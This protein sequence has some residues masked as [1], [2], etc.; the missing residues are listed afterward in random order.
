MAGES[1]LCAGTLK[2]ERGVVKAVR[3]N[4]GHYRPTDEHML[5]VVEFLKMI[6]APIGQIDIESH[7]GFI[8]S[9]ADA[10]L[11]NRGNW[12]AL[13]ARGQANLLTRQEKVFGATQRI[14]QFLV[15]LW[16]YSPPQIKTEDDY[17][18]YLMKVYGWSRP[19]AEARVWKAYNTVLP[20]A[21][22]TYAVKKMA[23]P[24]RPR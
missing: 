13:F 18:G 15:D 21:Q 7:N 6:G 16:N 14:D 4:S 9:K 3:T 11:S 2:I 19:K 20:N 17:Y 22:A 23:P 1:V 5:N 8:V 24:A 10:Y 12:Q